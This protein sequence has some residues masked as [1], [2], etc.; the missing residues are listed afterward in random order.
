MTM[1]KLMTAD[2]NSIP[3][4]QEKYLTQEE[5]IEMQDR[6]DKCYPD[7]IWWV[8]PHNEEDYYKEPKH[9]S[10]NTIDGWEDMYNY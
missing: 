5:A 4:I 3:V 9:Y 2:E 6:Y 10:S 8:M 7:Q 1:Y